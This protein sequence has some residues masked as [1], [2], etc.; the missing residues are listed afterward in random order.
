MK[1]FLKFSCFLDL[2]TLLTFG[3]LLLDF[4]FYFGFRQK[5]F[6]LNSK[7]LFIFYISFA[8]LLFWTKKISIS[9]FLNKLNKIL[10]PLLLISIIVF[11]HLENTNYINYLSLLLFSLFVFYLNNK[12][13]F[14]KHF[15]FLIPLFSLV[16][17]QIFSF[18]LGFQISV[19]SNLKAFVINYFLWLLLLVFCTSLFKKRSS[20]YILYSLIFFLFTLTNH[21]KIKFINL[22]FMINDVHLLTELSKVLP[23]ALRQLKVFEILII[24]FSIFLLIKFLIF[25][26]NK[27]TI[28]NP[29]L[30]IRFVLLAISVLILTYPIFYPFQFKKILKQFNIEVYIWGPIENCKNNGI[31]FCFYD[32]LKNFRNPPPLSYNQTKINDIYQ[33]IKSKNTSSANTPNN[34]PTVIVILS[35][36]FWD[37]TQIPR[38][39]FSTDPI[40]NI[41]KDITSTLISPTIGTATANVEFELLTGFSNYFLNGIIPYSQ[42]VRKNIP[43][44]FTAFKEN[45][46]KTTAIHSYFAGMYNRPQVYKNFGV[47]QYI[48]MEKMKDVEYAG[49]FISDKT[50]TKEI[51]KQYNSTTNPQFIFALSMQNHFPF[52][53]NIFGK[54]TIDIISSLSFD[55]QSIIQTYT[56]GINLSNIA[57]Q[58]LK[59]ELVKSNTPT[60]IVFFGDHIPLL[61]PGLQLY[62]DALF[63]ISNPIKAR[64]TPITIWSNFDSK[65]DIKQSYLSPTF[66]G[67]EILK[68]ANITPK[69]QFSY[70]QSISLIDT[71]LQTSIPPKFNDE[72][73]KNYELI[74]YDL[75]FGK[76]Y[77]LQ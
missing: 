40:S 6:Y 72:Q 73:L 24:I 11:Q 52:E 13:K 14:T 76:Q 27:I 30:I 50:L 3:S 23:D 58:Y 47:D 74:Q 2:L 28:I 18:N 62:Q 44:L 41:R 31:F 77:G 39:K 48:S 38:S 63:D 10:L 69:Y 61:N 22:F 35:E 33:K 37:I 7:N 64:S 34:K 25:I 55:N 17:S 1:K 71:V 16:L 53:K 66:L 65:I 54:H 32:D 51:L 42:T 15:Y 75:L 60:I 4:I 26:K 29:K 5:D 49:L 43:T 8:F 68:L 45:G 70:L 12:N 46:Y 56:Q 19:L 36:A 9:P 67:L 20:S 59:D 57:Y 21:L